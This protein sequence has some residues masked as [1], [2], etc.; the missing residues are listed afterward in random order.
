MSWVGRGNLPT[1]R[2]LSRGAAGHVGSLRADRLLE[3]ALLGERL[4]DEPVPAR[5]DDPRHR[6]LLGA[7]LQRDLSGL[8]VA[9]AERDA[10]EDLVGAD[11]EMLDHERL[12]SVP[13]GLVVPHEVPQ[14]GEERAQL[15]ARVLER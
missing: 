6:L 13:R 7:V 2:R 15:P 12:T 14:G 10:L 1:P 8:V 11:L 4:I 9:G 3:E 5:D